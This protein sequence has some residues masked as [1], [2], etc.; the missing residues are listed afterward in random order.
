MSFQALGR[1]VRSR[2]RYVARR[3]EAATTNAAVRILLLMLLLVLLS[4]LS[5]LSEAHAVVYKCGDECRLPLRLL[6][7][8]R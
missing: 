8:C 3:V 5:V 2:G 4:S 7:A 6:P 1:S